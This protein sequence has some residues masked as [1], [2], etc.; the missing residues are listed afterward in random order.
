[1]IFAVW[2]RR[3]SRKAP[4]SKSVQTLWTAWHCPSGN[5]RRRRA[6]KTSTI[7][8][9]LHQRKGKAFLIALGLRFGQAGNSA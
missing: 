3:S 8:A 5:R 7:E 1:M 6:R 9:A 2:I 4:S